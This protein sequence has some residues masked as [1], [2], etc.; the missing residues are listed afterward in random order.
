MALQDP[1]RIWRVPGMVFGPHEL[2]TGLEAMTPAVLTRIQHAGFTGVW[3]MVRL[4]DVTTTTVFPELG[5]EAERSQNDL[6]VLSSRC[7]Q[8]GLKLYLHLNEPRGFAA[9]DPFWQAHPDL[10]GAASPSVNDEGL[11]GWRDSCAMCTSEPRTLA[12]LEQACSDIFRNV[13]ELGGVECVTASEHTTHCY[14]H[15]D[16]CGSGVGEHHGQNPGD[17]L[18]CSHCR[19]RRPT[20]ILREVLLAIE[21]GVHAVSP[22]ADVIAWTWSWD[23]CAPSPQADLIESLP[24]GIIIMP[25]NERGGELEWNGHKQ[26]VDEYSL[27]YI[28]PSPRARE[29]IETA[30]QSGKRA[31]IRIQINHTVEFATAPN[32][33]LIANLYRKL[34]NLRAIGI[35]DAMAAWNFGNNPDTLNVFA[36]SRFL[37]QPEWRDEEAFLETV[38][39]DYFGL[40]DGRPAAKVWRAFGEAVKPYPFGFGILYFSP[41]NLAC[42]YPL[43]N[44]EPRTE[45]MQLWCFE[46]RGRQGDMLEQSLEPYGLAEI[47]ER[48]G[49]MYKLWHPA[50]AEYEVTLAGATDRSH[51]D[52]ELNVAR[53]FGHLVHSAWV[54]FSWFGWRYYPATVPSLDVESMRQRL[55]SELQNLDDAA[56]LLERD[57]RLGFYEEDR[58]YYVSPALVRAKRMADAKLLETL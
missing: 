4:R 23:M 8:A 36:L 18:D 55:R 2:E 52:Q 50:V 11:Y 20:D 31:M 9:D 25:D 22:S 5:A 56:A 35:S 38:A 16:A 32:W 40:A 33:P 14:S 26:R 6:R 51:A 27:N 58:K 1:I 57:S 13:P 21:Q 49:T 3:L 12:W 47:V 46:T 44:H 7:C 34:A 42:A 28:G 41:F 43:P 29:Q 10:R 17:I 15:F 45:S 54:L 53:F 48:L 19:E 37:R 30:R 24:A 39:C